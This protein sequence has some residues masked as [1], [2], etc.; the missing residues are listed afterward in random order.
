MSGRPDVDA[1][2]ETFKMYDADG[3]GVLDTEEMG[4]LFLSLGWAMTEVERQTLFDE[5]DTDGSGN[6]SYDEFVDW[7]FPAEED[8]SPSQ[9]QRS[10]LKENIIASRGSGVGV[11]SGLKGLTEDDI[12]DFRQQFQFFDRDGDGRITREEMKDALES[13][14]G[15][16]AL[17]EEAMDAWFD[18]VDADGNGSITFKEWCELMIQ[19]IRCAAQMDDF[20]NLFKEFDFDGNGEIDREEFVCALQNMQKTRCCDEKLLPYI[21]SLSDEDMCKLFDQA[22]VNHDGSIQYS[23]FVS[24]FVKDRFE[25]FMFT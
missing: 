7:L 15:G 23:E 2:K 14:E 17:D 1:M 13:L 8:S 19:K 16:Y 5:I 3:N 10:K 9:R 20:V 11:L 6:I 4:N 18:E 22:D 12:A 24:T 21:D 25:E